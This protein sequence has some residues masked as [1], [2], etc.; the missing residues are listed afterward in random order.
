[1]KF[2]E[3]IEIFDLSKNYEKLPKSEFYKVAFTI[4]KDNNISFEKYIEAIHKKWGPKVNGY[5]TKDY[6]IIYG[7][8]KHNFKYEVHFWDIKTG[9]KLSDIITG[10]TFN[11]VFSDIFN[12]IYFEHI[13][14]G[15]G[16]LVIESPS[17]SRADYYNKIIQY[18]IKKH[19]ID[20]E[21][22]VNGTKIII[23]PIT[24]IE[25]RNKSTFDEDCV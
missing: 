11:K 19:K 21:C 24:L 22:V 17:K 14:G 12:V 10:L 9:E 20:W 4:D 3:L 15:K 16:E 2:R 5:T 25:K 13:L 1:M 6:L 8:F 7:K 23:E 18:I